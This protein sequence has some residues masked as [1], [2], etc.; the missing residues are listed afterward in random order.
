MTDDVPEFDEILERVTS[1]PLQTRVRFVERVQATVDR[2]L[3]E[4]DDTPK[5]SFYGIAA[6]LGSAPS[7]EDIDDVRREV[8]ANFPREDI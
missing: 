1:M 8:W 7:A 5:Q 2:D 6:D 3:A 4:Q